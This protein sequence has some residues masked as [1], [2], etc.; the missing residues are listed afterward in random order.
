MQQTSDG[1]PRNST[2]RIRV[3]TVDD[4]PMLR[5]GIAAVVQPRADMVLVGEAEDGAQAVDAFRQLRPDVTLMDLQMP[6][7]NG[8]DAII[9]IRAE[10]PTARIIVLTT[11]AGDVLALRALR[12]GA[13][14][15]LLKGTLR[16]ELLDAIRTVH[17]GRK[18]IPVEVAQQIALHAGEDSLTEREISVLNLVST[19]H[20]N[21][22]IARVLSISEDTVKGHLKS[23]FSK[24]DVGDRTQA[25]TLAAKR[26]I[27]D[28]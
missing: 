25:V 8:V 15:Y 5:E 12:A 21:K 26:G 19:G 27:I 23:I 18:H 4:H 11:Y 3:L 22:E 17:A 7:L 6:N 16:K 24:L 1:E 2:D 9:K 20:A 28:L 13:V 10:F 14:G